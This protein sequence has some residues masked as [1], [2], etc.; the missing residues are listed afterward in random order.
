MTVWVGHSVSAPVSS[1]H[2]SLLTR[3]LS[4]VGKGYCLQIVPGSRPK[5]YCR[6]M[7]ATER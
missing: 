4:L 7:Y 3:S 5:S 1:W 6:L 2:A